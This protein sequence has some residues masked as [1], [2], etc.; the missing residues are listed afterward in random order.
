MVIDVW[1]RL[2]DDIVKSRSNFLSSSVFKKR[3]SRVKFDRFL[4][5]TD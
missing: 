5:V 1:N 3:L 2:N 4:T